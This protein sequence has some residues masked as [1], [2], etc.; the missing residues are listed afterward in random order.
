VGRDTDAH[1]VG[2]IGSDP[3]AVALEAI[4]Q[5]A[6]EDLEVHDRAQSELSARDRG[7]TAEA[8]VADSRNPRAE[9][10]ERAEPRARFHLREADAT[11]ALGVDDDPVGEV[12][13]VA[14]AAVDRVLEMRVRTDEAG[15]DRCVRI[16]RALAD[17]GDRADRDDASVLDHNGAV[18]DRCAFDRQHPV[19]GNDHGVSTLASTRGDRRS[20]NTASQ[21][22]PSNSAHIG[23][24][25]STVVTGSG[26]GNAS[27]T[28]ATMK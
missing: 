7:R 19:C 6:A 1:S 12:E 23:N 13:S 21:I 22:D 27:A 5:R 17:L 14:E 24:S 2:E 9:T 8:R 3:L 11:F 26:P 16:T 15:E 10:L 4:A 28:T 18:F 20:T 25:S